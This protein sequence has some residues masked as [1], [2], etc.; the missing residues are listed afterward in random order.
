MNI[1]NSLRNGSTEDT[2]E[3]TMKAPLD[4]RGRYITVHADISAGCIHNYLYTFK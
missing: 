4:Q 1:V 2:V 3:G